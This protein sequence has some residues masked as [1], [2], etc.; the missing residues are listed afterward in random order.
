MTILYSVTRAERAAKVADL[1]AA[2][3]TYR[4]IADELGISGSYVSDL[5]YDPDGSKLAARRVANSGVCLDCGGPTSGSGGR[6]KA[7]PR[8]YPCHLKF[9]EAQHGTLSRYQ[10]GCRCDPCRAA[11]RERGRALKGRTPPNHGYSGYVNYGCRCQVCRDGMLEY[12]RELRRRKA[13]QS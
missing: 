1:R 7:P 4:Q 5:I 11:N 3:R 9:I 2:G 10:A 13:A 8:C 12:A 6:S